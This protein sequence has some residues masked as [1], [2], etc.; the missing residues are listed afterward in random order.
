M[1]GPSTLL[2][3]LS[4]RQEQM[5]TEDSSY[6]VG[7]TEVKEE[8]QNTFEPSSN[9]IAGILKETK[10]ML[11]ADIGGG[12]KNKYK[13]KRLQHQSSEQ[14]KWTKVILWEQSLTFTS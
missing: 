14:R 5:D 11:K 7:V 10:E 3:D 6:N 2:S 9:F 8:L 12:N 1:N 4:K 13:K